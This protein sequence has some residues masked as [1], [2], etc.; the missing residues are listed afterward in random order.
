MEEVVA[1]GRFRIFLDVFVQ[2]GARAGFRRIYQI[3]A[4]LVDSHHIRGAQHA[5][6]R[7]DGHIVFR[8][9]VAVGRNVHDEA[10]VELR[11]AIDDSCRV[12][13]HLFA[14]GSSRLPGNRR[15]GIGRTQC[16]TTAAA[17]AFIGINGALPVFN[18]GSSVSAD[19]HAASAA[20]A[21]IRIDSHLA[22]AVLFHLTGPAAAAHA[23]IFNSPAKA[24]HFMSFKMVQGNNDIRFCQRFTDLCLFQHFPVG[25]RH[26]RFIVALQSVGND[27]MAAGAERIKAIGISRV[28]MFQGMLAAAHI[29]CVAVRQEG[30]APR[31]FYHVNNDL[32]I[33]GAQIRK[34][35]GLPKMHLDSYKLIFKINVIEPGLLH[36]LG[37]LYR[38]RVPAV[39]HVKIGKIHFGFC[40]DVLPFLLEHSLCSL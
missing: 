13:R 35:A 14:E 1:F 24:G 18:A 34:V 7:N 12:F 38:Q 3:G 32:C 10:D 15:N 16:Q 31:R 26:Q 37:Q 2:L 9:A 29:Q 30:T 5:D 28:Q 17:Q 23:D 40:H 19:V 39:R 27:H 11:L 22:V 20:N 4:G 36:Q 25:N 21:F 8:M 6:I 33:I